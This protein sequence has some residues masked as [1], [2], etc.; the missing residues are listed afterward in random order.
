MLHDKRISKLHDFQD[1][2]DVF[3]GL[4]IR[5]GICYSLWERDQ[6]GLHVK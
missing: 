1:T 6:N 4:N 2:N 3:P 5:G